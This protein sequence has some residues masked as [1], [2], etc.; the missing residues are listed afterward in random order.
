MTSLTAINVPGTRAPSVINKHQLGRLEGNLNA[1]ASQTN[2]RLRE[3][4]V[5]AH[6][7]DRPGDALHDAV[8]D[9]LKNEVRYSF[10]VSKSRS[11]QE[12]NGYFRDFET[13]ANKVFEENGG[14]LTFDPR[15]NVTMMVLPYEWNDFPYIFYRLTAGRSVENEAPACTYAI[16]GKQ[17]NRGIADAY[18][19]VPQEPAQTIAKVIM[20]GRPARIR[21]R[22][23]A[24]RA[25][26]AAARTGK[27]LRRDA[28]AESED[29]MIELFPMQLTGS[30]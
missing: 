14:T 3:V 13:I 26:Q 19:A 4:I 22:Q 23:G 20:E 8:R 7:V 11:Q 17:V 15:D 27:S 12:L 16:R 9:N 24:R 6:E 25:R 10:L 18:V 21:S 5:V 1:F 2:R 29:V 28:F 30:Q